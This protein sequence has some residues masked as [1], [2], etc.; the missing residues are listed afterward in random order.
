VAACN[1]RL[2]NRPRS[3]ILHRPILTSP[4]SGE[5]V[6]GR[7]RGAL[8]RCSRSLL[9]VR[10]S[11]IGDAEFVVPRPRKILPNPLIGHVT[12]GAA[13]AISRARSRFSLYLCSR[14]GCA[15]DR[16]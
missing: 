6:G 3:T 2:P 8:S 13:S 11:L 9:A 7:K 5:A 16:H 15:E 12:L 14:L 1:S 10:F 4:L